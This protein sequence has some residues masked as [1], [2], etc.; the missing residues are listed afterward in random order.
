VRMD[1]VV[2]MMT[3][4]SMLITFRAARRRGASTISTFVVQQTIFILHPL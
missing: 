2:M 4:M 1:V 3:R